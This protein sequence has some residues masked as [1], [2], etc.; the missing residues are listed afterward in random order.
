MTNPPE[1]QDWL[2]LAEEAF[3]SGESNLPDGFEQ[4]PWRYRLSSQ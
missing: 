4:L 1:D 2:R 3:G